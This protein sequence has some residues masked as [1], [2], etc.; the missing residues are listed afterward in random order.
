MKLNS[1]SEFAIPKP[2]KKRFTIPYNNSDLSM[3]S[4]KIK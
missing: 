4:G 3:S 1:V 2:N